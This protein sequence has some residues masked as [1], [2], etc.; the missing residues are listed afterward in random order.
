MSETP[1][2][3]FS[4]VTLVTGEKRLFDGLDL[5][6]AAGERVAVIGDS[7]SGK[8][9][10]LRLAIGLTRPLSGRITLFE[11]ELSLLCDEALRL[12]RTRC[13]LVFQNGSLISE[14]SVEDNLWLGLGGSTK[15]RQR[16]RRRLDRVMLE[17]GIEYAA[18]LQVSALS[19]GERRQVELARAF[20]RDPELVILDEPLDGIRANA[21][22]QE[23]QI[24]RHIVPRR[25]A[26]LLLT[27]DEEL[28]GRLCQRVL[29]LSQGRLVQQERVGVAP[30]SAM[31]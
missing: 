10:I 15:A 6:L 1:V 20:L 22:A 30:G 26:L 31:S 14:H 4:G 5:S 2:L 17:F 13:G 27:Q 8:S 18:D 12:R 25:R 28:A 23:A 3:T 9:M 11:D 19:S 24:L 29:R 21:A 16:L 7:G